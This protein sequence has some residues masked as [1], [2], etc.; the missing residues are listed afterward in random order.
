MEEELPTTV[1]SGAVNVY[2]EPFDSHSFQHPYRVGPV[3]VACE[4]LLIEHLCDYFAIRDDLPC[5]SE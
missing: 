2:H 1:I 5:L 4:R 3:A